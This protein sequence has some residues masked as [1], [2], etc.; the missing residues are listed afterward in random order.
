[1]CIDDRV[2]H[3]CR[4]LGRF[5]GFKSC[6]FYDINDLMLESGLLEDGPIILANKAMCRK[7]ASEEYHEQDDLCVDCLE[8][9]E[10]RKERTGAR[11]RLE[12]QQE[13]DDETRD[14]I[15][16]LFPTQLYDSKRKV[17][18]S[19]GPSSSGSSRVPSVAGSRPPSLIDP[20]PPEPRSSADSLLYPLP[21]ARFDYPI[22]DMTIVDME[23]FDK[24]FQIRAPQSDN[25][26]FYSGVGLSP[27][28]NEFTKFKNA[29]DPRYNAKHFGDV[30]PGEV[31]K[32][33]LF[34]YLRKEAQ[35]K[36]S[37]MASHKYSCIVKGRVHL[38]LHRDC[39]DPLHL[40]TDDSYSSGG[41]EGPRDSY[42]ELFEMW[43]L[44]SMG[45]VTEIIRYNADDFSK[46]GMLWRIGM[47]PLGKPP[48]FSLP[49]RPFKRD[50]PIDHDLYSCGL[51]I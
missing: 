14:T 6:Q 3:R 11:R 43:A 42:W 39:K 45:R 50:S 9:A 29:A 2:R 28:V 22:G 41:P 37:A 26:V 1:M 34:K 25:W 35:W 7:H 49:P 16:A 10:E 21:E 33:H 27:K 46:V 5:R 44:T 38:L 36:A 23:K 40:Y 32:T 48:D 15:K 51:W 20:A 31:V 8:K 24:F 18:F 17:K 47:T 12:E 19:I 13:V 30:Y 4:H